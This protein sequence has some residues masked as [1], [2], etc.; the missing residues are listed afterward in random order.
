MRKTTETAIPFLVIEQCQQY[1]ATPEIRPQGLRKIEFRIRDLPE[2]EIADSRFPTRSNED[3]RVRK[4][5]RGQ[6]LLELGFVNASRGFSVLN[7]VDQAIHG[8][9]NLGSSSITQGDRHGPVGE[10]FG[11][12]GDGMHQVLRG[13]GKLVKQ[14][15]GEKLGFSFLERLPFLMKK[16]FEKR[17]EQVDLGLGAIP[18]LL[19]ERVHRDDWNS[20][21]VKG[22]EDFPDG[23]QPFPMSGNTGQTTLGGPATVPIHDHRHVTREGFLIEL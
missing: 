21:Q 16:F 11:L 4:T 1:V 17:H 9:D 18:V 6:V 14:A 23:D 5:G 3:V 12:P 8:V 2:Q 15:N 13:S 22:I 19:R 20:Q 7:I 10:M